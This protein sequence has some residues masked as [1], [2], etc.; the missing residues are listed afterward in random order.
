MAKKTWKIGEC[1]RGGIIT[2]VA[3]EKKITVIGKDWDFSKGSTRGS[4]QSSAQ[5]F[6]R[7]EVDPSRGD[8]YRELYNFL[9]DLT[10]HFYAETVIDW[11]ETKTALT[12]KGLW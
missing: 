1:C 8:T 9:S 3:T 12:T 4:G 11:I 6:T 2:A 5:E 10:T 7:L